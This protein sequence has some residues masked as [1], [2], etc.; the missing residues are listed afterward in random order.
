MSEAADGG[1]PVDEG[2]D[3]ACWLSLVC[4]E[5][6]RVRERPGAGACEHC[7]ALPEGGLS[8]GGDGEAYAPRVPGLGTDDG[9]GDA[10]GPEGPE[11]VTGRAGR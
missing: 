7:G 6:G 3:P 11:D 8:G 4:E 1:E 5:C 2:G 9:A 10:T